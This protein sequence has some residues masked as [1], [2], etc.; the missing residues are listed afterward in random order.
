MQLDGGGNRLVEY[1]YAPG[2][3]RPFSVSWDCFKRRALEL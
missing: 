3:D 1:S 2:L